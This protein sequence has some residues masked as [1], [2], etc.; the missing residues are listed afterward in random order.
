MSITL[1]HTSAF[2]VHVNDP[3]ISRCSTLSNSGVP[4]HV[5]CPVI[6]QCSTLSNSGVPIDVNCPVIS[7]CSTLSNFGVPIHVN[8]PVIS[9]CSSVVILP[10]LFQSTVLSPRDVPQCVPYFGVPVNGATILRFSSLSFWFS[11]FHHCHSDFHYFISTAQ[12][13][14][15]EN[16]QRRHSFPLPLVLIS[17]FSCINQAVLH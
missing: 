10:F 2:A 13:A 5:S 7:R 4:I 15:D 16:V 3:T 11:L 8:C 14:P 1:F 12:T 9:R 17:V 6:S